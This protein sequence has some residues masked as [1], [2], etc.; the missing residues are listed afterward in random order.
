MSTND[1]WKANNLDWGR[2]M[3][4]ASMSAQARANDLDGKIAILFNTERFSSTIRNNKTFV[5]HCIVADSILS[6]NQYYC[7]FSSGFMD[8]DSHQKRYGIR[9]ACVKFFDRDLYHT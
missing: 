2:S 4:L 9:A 3:K 1:R 6:G 8:R 5:K 7:F